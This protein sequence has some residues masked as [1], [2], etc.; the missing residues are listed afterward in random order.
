V[1]GTNDR[2]CPD[3]GRTVLELKSA[4]STL[5]NSDVDERVALL[6]G[7][8]ADLEPFL[9]HCRGEAPEAQP[10]KRDTVG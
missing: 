4:L 6:R 1:V 2:T 9:E 7:G 8:W 3:C 5:A 10:R